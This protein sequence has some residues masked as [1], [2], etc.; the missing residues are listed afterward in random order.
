MS[1]RVR[2]IQ[3]PYD[4]IAGSRPTLRG[5]SRS[6]ALHVWLVW[7][8]GVPLVQSRRY[9]DGVCHEGLTGVQTAVAAGLVTQEWLDDQMAGS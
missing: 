4:R 3:S 9:V 1:A 2:F 8:D 5:H 7:D 6:S